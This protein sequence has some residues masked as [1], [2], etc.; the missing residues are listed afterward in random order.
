MW[1]GLCIFIVHRNLAYTFNPDRELCY[2]HL[3]GRCPMVGILP[4]IVV[5]VAVQDQAHPWGAQLMGQYPQLIGTGPRHH[6]VHVG[7][8]CP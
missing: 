3:Q 5:S 4:S 6:D 8:T 7:C 1:E 2:V